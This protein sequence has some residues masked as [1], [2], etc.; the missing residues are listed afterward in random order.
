MPW[1]VP[2][3][4]VD[5]GV[6]VLRVL[7]VDVGWVPLVLA[8]AAK[9]PI[10]A[11]MLIAEYFDGAEVGIAVIVPLAFRPRTAARRSIILEPSRTR[12]ADVRRPSRFTRAPAS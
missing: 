10:S 2:V 1:V 9:R 8:Q 7:A 3:A 5:G 4:A 11:I 6:A 12:A